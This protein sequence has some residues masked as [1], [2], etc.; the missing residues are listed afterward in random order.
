MSTL[1]GLNGCGGDSD[2]NNTHINQAPVAKIS[3]APSTV[4]LNST[5]KFDGSA[6]TDSDGS[7]VAYYWDGEKGDAIY[8][9]TFDAL[10][11]RVI[12]LQVEDNEGK[13]SAPMLIK[14]TVTENNAP[15]AV[16]SG[17]DQ[18]K[19]G[20][21]ATFDAQASTDSDGSIVT[22]LWNG[23][24]GDS[25]YTTTFSEEGTETVTLVV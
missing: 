4:L 18:V 8:S 5:V 17:P 25:T 1:V 12:T 9:R 22:Y 24:E 2:S 3:N 7:V 15:V 23:V 10:G 16:I 21:V 11:E 14:L 13:R 20:K 19:V 6:S